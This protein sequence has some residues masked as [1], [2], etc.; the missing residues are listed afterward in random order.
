MKALAHLNKYL[1]KYRWRLLLGF[2]FVLASN[3]FAI[4]PAQIIRHSFD[5]VKETIDVYA[6]FD[7]TDLQ[8]GLYKTF[9][10][11][12]LLFGLVVLGLAIIKGIFT[13]FM[14]QTIIVMSR[15]IEYDLRNEIFDHYQQLSLSF[16]KRN[17]TGDM[18]A[19]VTEDVSRVRMY[20]GPAIMYTI[21]LVGLFILVIV[22]M[23]SVNP[24][25]T[26]YVLI[27]LPILS[28][29]IY[30]VQ[31]IINQ[32]SEQ[33]QR[34]LSSLSTYVQ[35]A[36]SGIRVL[37]AFVREQQ[38]ADDFERES[39]TYHD[40]SMKLVNVNAFFMP[41][42][43]MLIGLSTLITV[44]VGGLE[45]IRGEI[46][47]G[48]I[49]EFIIY[50]NML[51]WPVA[52][53]GWVTSLVQ[54]AAASQQRINEFLETKPEISSPSKEKIE[55]TGDIEFQDVTFVYPDSGITAIQNLSFR[56][57]P[58]HSL[59]ILGRTGSGKSTVANLIT[60]SYDVTSGKVLIDGR[61]I[62]A[63][64][65]DSLRAQLGYVPQDVFLFSDTIGNNI[66]FGLH[67]QLT[68]AEMAQV[69]REAARQAVVSHNIEAFPDGYETRIGERGI[70]LSGGQKQRVSIARAIIRKPAILLFDDC[71][72]AVDTR[73]EEAILH[74][75]SDIMDKRTTIIISHRVSSVK[76]TNHI[77]VLDK[78]RVIEQGTHNE[79]MRVHGIYADMY[80]KQKLEEEQRQNVD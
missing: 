16:Y 64:R 20:L 65:L 21:N 44:Y 80:E 50:V 18:M 27:P 11:Y 30:M 26:L 12:L 69:T 36:F 42:M 67:D 13:F 49:A 61:D 9:G 74:N 73:T 66:A 56:I 19:R 53:L 6:L 46:T 77:L 78:G 48:N 14:R 17:S 76:H 5:L 47:I 28:V 41:I 79:L 52:A 23:I 68:D 8:A 70:T 55:I 29:S 54:R 72:S 31:N 1:I 3:M 59:A 7:N 43:L 60:R 58:G 37:K 38:S 45:T 35:E 10:T 4:F 32:R 62:R 24:R 40:L 22:T 57:K 2:V 15:L 34:Q 39:N 75:L 63:Y 51:T 71:L 25:L 33:V